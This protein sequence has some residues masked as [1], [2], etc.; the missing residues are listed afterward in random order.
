MTDTPRKSPDI[1]LLVFLAAAAVLVLGAAVLAGYVLRGPIGSTIGVIKRLPEEFGNPLLTEKIHDTPP[2]FRSYA[3]VEAPGFLLLSGFLIDEGRI[4]VRLIDLSDGSTVRS[5]YPDPAAIRASSDYPAF[6]AVNRFEPQSPWLMADG[7]LVFIDNQGPLVRID[8]CSE[9]EWIADGRFH[10]SLERDLDGNF[11]VPITFEDARD[12]PMMPLPFRDDGYAIVSP[13]GEILE[14][15]SLTDILYRA[16]YIGLMHTAYPYVD[17]YVHLNDA[18]VAGFDAPGW[19]RGDIVFSLRKLNALLLYR[20]STEEVTWLA[21]G[22]WL[23]QHDPDFQPD[24]TLAVFS[25]DVVGN[26]PI[27]SL[28]DHASIWFVDPA[29]GASEQRYADT[30]RAQAIATP[31]QG[32]LRILDNGDAFVEETDHGR[33]MRISEDGVVWSY[34]NADESDAAVLNWSRFLTAGEVAAADL[35]AACN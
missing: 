18:E 9:I 11:I 32:L 13:A 4:G 28:T 5:W 34:Y 2:G 15:R 33:L 24:G 26:A 27:R 22:P 21:S 12:Y 14:T 20:P 31:T 25:N 10:H 29:T 30:L 8:A 6:S 35:S 1:G 7:G 17:D 23:K 19:R 3:A 16:G